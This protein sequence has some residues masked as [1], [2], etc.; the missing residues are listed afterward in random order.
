[1]P[2]LGGEEA[3]VPLEMAIYA[4]TLGAAYGMNL[5]D[6]IG[7]LEVVKYADLIVLDKNLF[8]IEPHMIDKAKVLYTVMDGKL[9]YEAGK[10]D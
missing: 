10:Q 6:K 3:R 9:V 1:M 8:D 2:P 4:Q 5:S 7:S